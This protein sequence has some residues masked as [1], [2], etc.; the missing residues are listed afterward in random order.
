MQ[1]TSASTGTREPAKGPMATEAGSPMTAPADP[2]YAQYKVIRRN[3]AVVPFEPAKIGV[4]MTKA[5]LAVNGGQGADKVTVVVK[6]SRRAVGMARS[7][8]RRTQ[9]AEHHTEALGVG[10]SHDLIQAAPVVAA[11][12][13][14][15]VA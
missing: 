15:D 5:F 13:R 10:N 12:C 1:V 2:R 7:P 6:V 9:D 8:S 11:L 4:A 14:L 3:G